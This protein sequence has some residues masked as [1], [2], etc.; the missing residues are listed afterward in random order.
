[1][2]VVAVEDVVEEEVVVA[3]EILGVKVEVAVPQEADPQQADKLIIVLG[4]KTSHTHDTRH[5]DMLTFPQYSHVS[6]TGPMASQ[7]TFVWSR[8]PARGR[9]SS[10]LKTNRT[11]TSSAPE[12]VTNLTKFTTRCT[13][14]ILRAK[15]T[16]LVLMKSI[17]WSQSQV[18][19][20]LSGVRF[21]IV[22]CGR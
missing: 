13:T 1:M 11:G 8:P 17:Q 20:K 19:Y 9:T 18:I 21:K 14:R 15:Y 12:I 10:P 5:P 3:E 6:G 16:R 22:K 7:L 4:V 2:V